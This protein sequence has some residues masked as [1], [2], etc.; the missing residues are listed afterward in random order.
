MGVVCR[1]VGRFTQVSALYA[2]AD[3][4]TGLA[5]SAKVHFMV[6]GNKTN[7]VNKGRV[8][9]QSIPLV[10]YCPIRFFAVKRFNQ[11]P[12]YTRIDLQYYDDM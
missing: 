3:Y 1:W 8:Y 10:V 4:Y 7:A 5:Y 6:V 2:G 9:E 12:L 11:R